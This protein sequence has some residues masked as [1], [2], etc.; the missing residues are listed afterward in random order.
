MGVVAYSVGAASAIA[1]P[2][3][4]KNHEVRELVRLALNKPES[5]VSKIVAISLRLFHQ[6]FPD[7]KCVVSFADTAQGH[8]GTIYQASNWLYLGS[9][10]YHAYRVL[11]RI[12]HPKTLHTR[13]GGNGGQSV[14]WLRANVDPNAERIR[15]MPKHKYLFCFDPSL[16]Q[17][18]KLKS[19]PYPKG[20]KTNV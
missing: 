10:S 20:I 3:G 18:W 9:K 14:A 6:D 8:V 11:G 4:L 13:Y 17:E 19:L 15:T 1:K 2:F 5:P 16:K 7:V 12:E